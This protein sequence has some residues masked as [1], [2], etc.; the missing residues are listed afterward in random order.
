MVKIP[1]PLSL[2]LWQ[3][4]REDKIFRGV[5]EGHSPSYIPSPSPYKERGIKGERLL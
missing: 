4:E 2:S 3:R 5:L 1:H